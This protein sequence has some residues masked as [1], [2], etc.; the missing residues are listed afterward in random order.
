MLS[1][2][3]T[4]NVLRCLHSFH[5]LVD[6]PQIYLSRVTF[7]EGRTVFYLSTSESDPLPQYQQWAYPARGCTLLNRPIIT[8]NKHHSP[9]G[10]T[11]GYM[12]LGSRICSGFIIHSTFFQ[13]VSIAPLCKPCTSY[14]RDGRPSV[15]LSVRHTLSLSENE[16]NAS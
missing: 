2:W 10:A 13:G 8:I 5:P 15:C 1:L 16:N 9:G 7:A 11:I 14:D 6:I 12:R 3:V 4:G